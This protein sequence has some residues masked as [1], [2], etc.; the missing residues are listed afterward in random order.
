MSGSD[1]EEK[2]KDGVYYG[3]TNS[4]RPDVVLKFMKQNHALGKQ[5]S[6]I[7]KDMG[8]IPFDP[9]VHTNIDYIAHKDASGR[10]HYVTREKVIF[11]TAFDAHDLA[12]AGAL[13]NAQEA[14]AKL[15]PGVPA[16]YPVV[17][18]LLGLGAALGGIYGYEAYQARKKNLQKEGS[19]AHHAIELAGLG[20]LGAPA[21][22]ELAGK[23]V[24]DRTKQL[25]EI[26][27]LGVLAAPSVGHFAASAWGKAKPFVKGF[28]KRAEEAT[29]TDKRKDSHP[30]QLRATATPKL[31]AGQALGGGVLGG[32]LGGLHGAAQAPNFSGRKALTHGL[33]GAGAGALGGL[34][35]ANSIDNKMQSHVKAFNSGARFQ[36]A[37]MSK[38]AEAPVRD[39]NSYLAGAMAGGG[40]ALAGSQGDWKSRL[41]AGGVGTLAG[42]GVGAGIEEAS[43]RAKKKLHE[44]G[45]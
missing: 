43:Y 4:D 28:A 29:S 13:R 11:K 22:A 8:E 41:L 21:A 12:V 3:M 18:G 7:G 10:A 19:A 44:M 36:H 31:Y 6:L 9:K 39:V 5:V 2:R 24:S 42:L 23:H 27:G 16:R 26:G 30:Y 34:L 35:R 38:E 1:F 33:L 45:T 15:K 40:A 32:V 25:A 17:G 37:Q 20:I 14:V